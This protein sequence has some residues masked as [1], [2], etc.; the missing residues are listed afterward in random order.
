MAKLK[1]RGREEIFRLE[2]IRSGAREGIAEVKEYRVLATDGNVL[3]R[4]VIYYTPEEVA[5]NYGTKSHD[6]GWK[7]RGLVKAGLT[8]E[9]LLK[10]Y[11]D[12]GWQLAY[13]NSAYFTVRGDVIEAH[14]QE[15][16][17]DEGEAAKRRERLAAGRARAETKRET[18]RRESDG[19]GFYVTNGFVGSAT[20]TR[21]ADHP[22]P[23][24]TYE[25]AE[26]FATRRLQNFMEFSFDYLL[27]VIVI[28]ATS[29]GS[30]ED[31]RGDVLWINGQSKGPAVDPRQTGFNF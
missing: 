6:Y 22:K 13:A 21:I 10:T 27:P 3:E 28:Q 17:R 23:F 12:R 8:L 1:A 15:S 29:R 26:E 5:K 7:V 19:P 18:A 9:Q 24:D 4:M 20:R 30:A 2:R 14:S 25:K 11:L 16:I 31:M